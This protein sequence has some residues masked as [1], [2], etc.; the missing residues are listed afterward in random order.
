M[1]ISKLVIPA[2]AGIQATHNLLIPP[3]AGLDSRF[4][5][6]DENGLF[7]TFYECIN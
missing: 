5:G 1:T 7:W 4:H 3:L 6:N 2:Q